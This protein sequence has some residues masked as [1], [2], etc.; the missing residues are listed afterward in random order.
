M[1]KRFLAKLAATVFIGA[2]APP[3]FSQN[4]KVIRVVAPYEAGTA[5][6]IWTRALVKYASESLGQPMIV[7]NKPG[8]GG[9]IGG[10]SVINA[11][12]DGSVIFS[13]NSTSTAALFAL[14]KKPPYNPTEALAGITLS[15]FASVYL[16]ASEELHVNNL[17]ELLAYAHAHGGELRCANGHATGRIACAKLGQ[18]GGIKTIE[19]SYKGETALIG[20]LLA[21]RVDVTFGTPF[22][23]M[24]YVEKGKLKVIATIMAERTKSAPS[25]PTMAEAGLPG[26][27][28]AGWNAVFV[29][30]AVP[31]AERQK[32]AN[33]F[34]FA[35]KQP[36]VIKLADTLQLQIKTNTPAE[37]DRFLAGE[38]TSY[39]T[40][41]TEAG[42]EI[43]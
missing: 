9:A 10:L 14:N 36:E 35:V 2:I 3:S 40:I 18:L 37:M 13:G 22:V 32:L 19:V 8:G 5:T 29:P 11:P 38:V 25:V 24:P 28:S 31:I 30:K 16:F 27:S 20:D 41:V 34:Y 12:A 4:Q 39:K 15:S 26:F 42:M 33:A 1:N 21:G 43:E 7:E 23:N 17:T 6:D